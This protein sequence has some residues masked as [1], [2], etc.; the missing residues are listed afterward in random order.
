[1][2][3]RLTTWLTNRYHKR[4]HASL[5]GR[6]PS[7][8]WAE[9]TLVVRSEDELCEA[10]TVRERRRVRGDCTLAVGNVDWELR[11]AFLAGRIVTVART[12]A[13]PQRAPWVEHD[14]RLYRLELVDVVAN[15]K[16]RK[17]KRPKKPGLD[18][19]DFDPIEVLLDRSLGRAPRQAKGGAR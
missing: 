13:D 18:A 17:K 9:R 6:S 8:A 3:V 2:Q 16:L 1:M 7:D 5:L 12:L 14:D 11:E 15:G 10:L 19:V 4:A